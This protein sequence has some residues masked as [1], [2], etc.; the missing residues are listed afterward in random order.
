MNNGPNLCDNH[1]TPVGPNLNALKH[2]SNSH[3]TVQGRGDDV[4]FQAHTS[5]HVGSI[6]V[7]TEE[8]KVSF[9]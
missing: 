9:Y 2:R 4:S 6:C 3:S 5:L 8:E 1:L 7:V